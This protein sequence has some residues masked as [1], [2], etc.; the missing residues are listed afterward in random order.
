ML[1]REMTYFQ[2]K[3]SSKRVGSTLSKEK[4]SCACAYKKPS[5]EYHKVPWVDS[6]ESVY[7]QSCNI[8]PRDVVPCIV[9]GTHLVNKEERLLCPMLWGMIPP[10]HKGDYK[11]H[12]AST[13]NSRLDRI[14]ESKLYSTPLRKGFKCIV[15]FDGFYEWKAGIN[16]SP[17]QP[18]YIH[19]KQESGINPDDPTTWP[20]KWSPESGWEGYKPLKMAGI[21]NAFQ[22]DEGKIVYSCSV[23]TKESNNVLSWLHDRTPIFLDDEQCRLW[24]DLKVSPEK[25]IEMLKMQE[26]TDNILSW[27]TVSTLVNNVSHKDA[28]CREK[29]E[30]KEKQK[31]SSAVFMASWLK[32]ESGGKSN[33]GNDSTNSD[34]SKDEI[35]EDE[36][37]FYQKRIFLRRQTILC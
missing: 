24:L 31:N 35:N 7:V 1:N 15:L 26:L 6:S 28:K 11:K 12:T 5:G 17:K 14:L 20:D 2:A 19:A 34:S 22:T 13:H 27:Y 23:L 8:G 32:K 21:F 33:S 25:A 18:Y 9:A 30:V 4:L 16:K 10:W 36:Q 29:I 37:T 3:E